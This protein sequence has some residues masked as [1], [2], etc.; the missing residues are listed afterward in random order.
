[1]LARLSLLSQ[2]SSTQQPADFFTDI[3]TAFPK[4]WL[5]TI[6]SPG[7]FQ[8]FGVGLGLL[9]HTVLQTKEFLGPQPLQRELALGGLHTVSGYKQLAGSQPLPV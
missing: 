1:M 8:V 3:R 7:T 2:S 5:W 9:K 6:G 4:L